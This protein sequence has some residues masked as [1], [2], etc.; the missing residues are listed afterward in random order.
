VA[1]VAALSAA[2]LG[3]YFLE[4]RSA[5]A[6]APVEVSMPEAGSVEEPDTGPAPDD[7]KAS[8]RLRRDLDLLEGKADASELPVVATDPSAPFDPS[9]RER[10][11]PT[12]Y[13]HVPGPLPPMPL[14][15]PPA[16]C[17]HPDPPCPPK[18]SIDLGY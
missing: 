8:D 1:G 13:R 2:G 4:M 11:A 14:P 18:P 16:P 12:I 9:L 10:L 17:G 7:T 3:V 6:P 15:P 5:R